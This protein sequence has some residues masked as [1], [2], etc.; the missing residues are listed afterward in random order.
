MLHVKIQERPFW[1]G[2]SRDAR[3]ASF[4]TARPRFMMN[5]TAPVCATIY[6]TYIYTPYKYTIYMVYIWYIYIWYGIYMVGLYISTPYIPY[7][8]YT[9]YTPYILYILYIT[10]L[11]KNTLAKMNGIEV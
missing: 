7:T 6:H 4:I 1:F 8:P 11:P 9:P 3:T 5:A 2:R 10:H